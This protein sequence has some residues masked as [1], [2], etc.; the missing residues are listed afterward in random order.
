[1]K[2][3]FISDMHNAYKK[4]GKD[5]PGGDLIICSGDMTGRGENHEVLEF[6]DWYNQLRF[7]DNK[8]F[9]AGNHDFAFQDNPGIVEVIKN[10]F[11]T[12]TY[13]QD[14]F[15]IVNDI[16]GNP[17]KIY[18]TPW[19]P[20]F[21]NWAFN[22]PKNGELLNDVWMKIPTDTDILITH[23]P[24][25]GRLDTLTYVG[26]L[27]CEL[28]AKRLKT[29]KPKIHA[30]GHIHDGYGYAYDNFTHYINA[31]NFN[32]D[33]FYANKPLTVEWDINTNELTFV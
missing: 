6:C 27:G 13:L 18:G 15:V 14:N 19:Q 17:V 28:L 23:G 21:N 4:I 12:I 24:P 7:Y 11:E 22:L 9:I 29:V 3:T 30:F 1:M 20:E 31:A 26:K 25:Y 8:I 16:Y 5:L 33:Y 2:I 10:E 32:E